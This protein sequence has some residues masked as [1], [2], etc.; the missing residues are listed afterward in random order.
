MSSLRKILP[1]INLNEPEIPS[2]ILDTLRVTKEDFENAMKY[3]L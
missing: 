2:E 1:K 3:V